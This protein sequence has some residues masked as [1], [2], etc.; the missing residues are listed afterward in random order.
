[1]KK[2]ISIALSLA[3]AATTTVM[4]VLPVSART[5]TTK[6]FNVADIKPAAATCEGFYAPGGALIGVKDRHL[7]VQAPQYDSGTF[8]VVAPA[9]SGTVVVTA[10]INLQSCTVDTTRGTQG[11]L[12]IEGKDGAGNWFINKDIRIDS[13]GKVVWQGRTS[14]PDFTFKKAQWYRFAIT[15]DFNDMNDKGWPRVDATITERN[16]E[17][18]ADVGETITVI[19]GERAEHTTAA[20][21]TQIGYALGGEGEMWLDNFSIVS[22]PAFEI[23]APAKNSVAAYDAQTGKLDGNAAFTAPSGFSS[24]N[25]ALN[26]EVLETITAESADDAYAVDLSKASNVNA[27]AANKLTVTAQYADGVKSA[28]TTFYAAG[29]SVLTDMIASADFNGVTQEDLDSRYDTKRYQ[30]AGYFTLGKN[31]TTVAP[32][33]S[34]ISNVYIFTQ[35]KGA[36]YVIEGADGTGDSAIEFRYNQVSSSSN[37]SI[38][39]TGMNKWLTSDRFVFEMDTRINGTGNAVQ[40]EQLFAPSY[41][42][43]F[44]E[45]GYIYGDTVQYVPDEW[46]TLKIEMD[47][48][49]SPFKGYIYYDGQLAY[50]QEITN[51]PESIVL[52]LQ[53]PAGGLELAVDNVKFYDITDESVEPYLAGIGYTVAGSDVIAT[54]AYEAEIPAAAKT[55]ELTMS[56]AVAADTD[57]NITYV[58]ARGQNVTAAN[59][60][61]ISISGSGIS[62]PL[63]RALTAGTEYTIKVGD[64]TKKFTPYASGINV[65]GNAAEYTFFSD[66]DK[67]VVLIIAG[68]SADGALADVKIAPSAFTIGKNTNT[69]SLDGEYSQVKAFCWNNISDMCPIY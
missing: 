28:E 43:L 15:F 24:L 33:F 5:V 56:K 60:E 54:D 68:Y 38:R 20:G 52:D 21:L 29:K 11:Q 44:K 59:K 61:K 6:D 50:S 45:N 8:A 2:I 3:M 39:F 53:N 22:N 1:M 64:I 69:L 57:V 18:T 23:T 36:A 58:N 31:Y 51:K 37:A 41:F 9:L 46:K 63:S 55:I 40:L 10:D 7:V 12:F 14:A 19:S 34:K 42:K 4:T 27:G 47:Y 62:I 67:T 30:A 16:A 17:N 25:V 32:W 49:T 48:T 26:G 65:T 13:E 35:S 66:S